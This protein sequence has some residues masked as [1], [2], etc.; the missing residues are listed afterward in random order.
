MIGRNSFTLIELVVAI[1]ISVV[2]AS[3]AFVNY[4]HGR[5]KTNEKIAAQQLV[6][7][8]EAMRGYRFREGHYPDSSVDLTDVDNIND[9]LNVSISEDV[10]SFSCSGV[11]GGGS[12]SCTASALNSDPWELTASSSSLDGMPYCSASSESDCLFCKSSINGGCPL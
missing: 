6:V 4:K 2:V 10:A 12:F 5:S 9:V 7:I 3:F 8:R 11:V 1:T